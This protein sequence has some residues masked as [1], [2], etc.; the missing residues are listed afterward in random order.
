MKA[1]SEVFNN[2]FYKLSLSSR[3]KVCKIFLTRDLVPILGH[4][5]TN[6]ITISSF[7]IFKLLD[8]HNVNKATGPD[9]IGDRVLKETSS[10]SAPILRIILQCSLATVYTGIIH[11]DWKA[12]NIIVPI[13][14]KSDR[15]NP[16]NHRPIS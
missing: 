8:D 11:D 14:K 10:V 3:L 15:S 1:F 12:A 4:S 9:H 16:A 2:Y 5:D 6:D 7:G 13:H